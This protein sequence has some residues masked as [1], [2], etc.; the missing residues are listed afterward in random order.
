ML[1]RDGVRIGLERADSV[2]DNGHLAH[3]GIFVDEEELERL[4]E[5]ARPPAVKSCSVVSAHW[6]STIPSASAGS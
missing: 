4:R 1:Y 6:F 5:F 3:V 2:K